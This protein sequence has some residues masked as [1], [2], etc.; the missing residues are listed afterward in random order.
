MKWKIRDI[1]EISGIVRDKGEVIFK[2]SGGNDQ[3]QGT[4]VYPLV[5]A[6]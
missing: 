6:F 5:L 1:F 3:I 2:G 4:R